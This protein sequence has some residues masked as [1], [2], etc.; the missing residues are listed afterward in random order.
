V[1]QM[2]ADAAAQ[3]PFMALAELQARIQGDAQ[4]LLVL[5]VRERDAYSNGAGKVHLDT[6]LAAVPADR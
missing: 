4:D 1:A 3:V 6:L 5:D 2:L